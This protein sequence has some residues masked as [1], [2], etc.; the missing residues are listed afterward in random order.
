MSTRTIEY[1]GETFTLDSETLQ[2]YNKHGKVLSASMRGHYPA[3]GTLRHRINVHRLFAVAFV[4]NPDNLP[5]VNHKDEDKMNW[6]PDNL[7][8]CTHR[9][10]N[11]YSNVWGY[12]VRATRKPVEAIFPDGSTQ[13]FIGVNDAAR[14]LNIQPMLV[15]NCARGKQCQTHGLRFRFRTID[16][17]EGR[18]KLGRQEKKG[19]KK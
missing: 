10:N 8:W 5:C 7:E 6:N 17:I 14:K 9:Y 15:S 16:V 19:A 4:P 1:M 11:K 2:V 3:I 12:A 18:Q 13:S